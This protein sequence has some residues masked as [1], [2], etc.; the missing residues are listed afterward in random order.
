MET[1]NTFNYPTI[2]TTTKSLST[3]QIVGIAVGSV[4]LVVVI[5][6]IVVVLRKKLTAEPE[7][8]RV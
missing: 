8:I 3:P 6:V 2:P 5:V 1:S 7:S 4:A